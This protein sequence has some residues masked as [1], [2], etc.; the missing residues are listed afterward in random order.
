[1]AHFED[2]W[3]KCEEYHSETTSS[4]DS[5][6]I[7]KEI[8]M[9]LGLYDAINRQVDS[10]VEDKEKAKSRLLGEI[11]FSLTSLSLKDNI[12]VYEALQVALM[13]HNIDLYSDKY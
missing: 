7:V 12:N 5:E 13:H 1:M 8:T 11:L 6:S 9:K 3:E 2:L 4:D 10:S